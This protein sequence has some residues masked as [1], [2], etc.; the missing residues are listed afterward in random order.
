VPSDPKGPFSVPDLLAEAWNEMVGKNRLLQAKN[1]PLANSAAPNAKP[2]LT[3]AGPEDSQRAAA[4]DYGAHYLMDLVPRGEGTTSYDA[5]YRNGDGSG[6]YYPSGW[7][8][9]TELTI[10][11]AIR[12]APD[13]TRAAGNY[14]VGLYQFKPGLLADAKRRMNLTG[15]EVLTPAMQDRIMRD[16]LTYRGYDRYLASPKQPADLAKFQDN[17]VN[18]WPSLPNSNAAPQFDGVRTRVPRVTPMAFQAAIAQAAQEADR[19]R[20]SYI[21]A[22]QEPPPGGRW[23]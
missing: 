16:R 14:A 18:E 2:P 20:D 15:S 19:I 1:D 11:E 22:G 7:K 3:A 6:R 5:S 21:D 12:M 9:P 8:K 17:L 13:M 4:R 10:D 23:R